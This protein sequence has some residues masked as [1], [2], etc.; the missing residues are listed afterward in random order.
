MEKTHHCEKRAKVRT[1][2]SDDL[3]GD[4]LKGDTTGLPGWTC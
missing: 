3:R 2:E 1:P 4:E